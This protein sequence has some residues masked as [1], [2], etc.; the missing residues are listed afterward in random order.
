MTKRI[1]AVFTGNRAEYGLQLPILRAIDAHPSL[2]YRLIVSGAHLDENFGRTLEEIE[3]DGYKVHAEVK[4]E[5]K[6][7]T[8]YSTA[9]AIG[10]GILSM[11]EALNELRP[12]LLTVYADR[13]EG[14]AA[15]IAG[16]Q[17][18][19]PTAHIEGGDLTEGGALDDSVRHA[20]TK[21]SHLHFT[22]NRQATNRILAMGEE[23]W[24]IH[25][26][27]FPAIDL[28]NDKNFANKEE[29]QSRFK[30]DL[31]KPIVL[32]TQHSVTTEFGK[33]GDQIE[34]SLRA[35]KRLSISGVQVVITYPN[36][37]AGGQCIID[38]LYD[39]MK[40]APPN[41]QLHRSV[42]RYNYHG[43]LALALD[44]EILFSCVGNSSSGIKETPAFGC[45]TVNIGSRQDG[46][47][48]A[49]NVIDVKY[50]EDAIFKAVNH[51]F[52]DKNFRDKCRSCQNPYGLGDAGEKI[53]EVLSK[54]SLDGNLLRKR[55][56][57]D[58][59]E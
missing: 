43:I 21:L 12:D 30:L 53:S 51:C 45:P 7:D 14:F 24:R 33:A 57:L 42:G 18:N 40:S 48:R 54:V 1:V 15:V 35:L 55:M 38:H 46:R 23:P 19:I 36:N 59:E 9:Q 13:F 31:T 11:S 29:L 3:E 4:I 16:T 39:F 26:V 52:E 37:D 47:L 25:T 41:I 5:I 28:I 27:G 50:D 49:E 32:F 56:T 6:E 58:G 8:L 44:Q 10:S 20:M 17:M 22:T 34:P 2:D